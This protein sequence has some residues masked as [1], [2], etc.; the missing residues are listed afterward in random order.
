[1]GWIALLPAADRQHTL[2]Q[3]DAVISGRSKEIEFRIADRSGREH[4]LHTSFDTVAN[5][6]DGSTL[7]VGA[8]RDV[9]ERKRFDEHMREVQR[10][11]SLGVLAGGI[12]HDFNNMLTV[13]RGNARLA[14]DDY[15]SARDPRERLER[16]HTAA[17]Y[18]T[19]LT[20]EMPTYS[21]R[22][23]VE[24]QSLDLCFVHSPILLLTQLGRE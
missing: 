19:R 3:V 17:E 15:E 1:M 21:G 11:E 6:S 7:I 5:Q 2:A 16:I 23:V 10:L 13:I 24:L 22:G 14:M 12:A 4:W 9:T 18:A 8:T 20:Q